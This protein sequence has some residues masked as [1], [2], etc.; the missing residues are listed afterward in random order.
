MFPA[1]LARSQVALSD[2]LGQSATDAK[3]ATTTPRMEQ[4]DAWVESHV[5]RLL[6]GQGIK[7]SDQLEAE[8]DSLRRKFVMNVQQVDEAAAF[9]A[10][11]EFYL[12]SFAGP[13]PA[14]DLYVAAGMRHWKGLLSSASPSVQLG[15]LDRLMRHL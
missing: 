12:D 3:P 5:R 2:K 8:I 13:T 11:C 10:L 1:L 9:G 6:N 14:P 4:C 7:Q 15:I